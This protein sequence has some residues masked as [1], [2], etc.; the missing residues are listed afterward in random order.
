MTKGITGHEPDPRAIYADIIDKQHWQSPTRP[1]MSLYDRAA[2]F[3]PFAA[4]TGYDDMVGEE[5]RLVDNKIELDNSELEILNGKL[6]IIADAI[7][8]GRAPEV[9]ITYFVPDL[10]KDG[11]SYK[12]ITEVIKKI[13]NVRQQLVL[14]RK[15][16]VAQM[17]MTID[18]KDILEIH[19]EEADR[20]F[21]KE[22]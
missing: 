9:S 13:D 16:G 1:H 3:A 17:N 8:E 12:T 22:F 7:A 2:Q 21:D 5:A 20:A 19:G 18:I 15:T 14:E 6:G 4:L 10:L 11:G